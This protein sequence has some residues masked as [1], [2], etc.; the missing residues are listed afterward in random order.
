MTRT[1]LS[2][3]HR[4]NQLLADAAPHSPD[5]LQWM[6]TINDEALQAKDPITV[7]GL[8]LVNTALC[9]SYRGKQAFR[10]YQSAS[11][12]GDREGIGISYDL[13]DHP[14]YQIKMELQN[15]G[16]YLGVGWEPREDGGYAKIMVHDT[17]REPEWHLP[18]Y[19]FR[20]ADGVTME[21][22][23]FYTGSETL[24]RTERD[25]QTR[26]LSAANAAL[27]DQIAREC[28]GEGRY[29]DNSP[30]SEAKYEAWRGEV[31]ENLTA[32]NQLHTAEQ[33][34][35]AL[36]AEQLADAAEKLGFDNPLEKGMC[37]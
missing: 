6:R 1:A 33:S 13:P 28:F 24:T 29:A 18:S 37:R 30:E 15:I 14:F 16:K 5:N 32:L 27:E 4:L 34:G 9:S 10:R 20:V 8:D 35:I 2:E 11:L 3:A 23:L 31:D 26:A 36:T 17:K 22:D 12:T 7:A 19:I 25:Q 21:Q